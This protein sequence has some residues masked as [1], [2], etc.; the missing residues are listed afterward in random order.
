MKIGVLTYHNTRNCGAVLQAY[1]LQKVLLELGM[2][3]EIIDYRCDK[4]EETYRLRRLWEIK[5]I[6]MF[7]KW[8]LKIKSDKRTQKKFEDFRKN[9]LMLSGAYTKDNIK[10]AN[11]EFDGFITGSDQV[12][13]FHL[14]GCDY[15]Y[16]LDFA[17]MDKRKISYAASMGSSVAKDSHNK[18]FNEALASFDLVSVREKPLEEY[19]KR[20][21]GIS[22]TL[23]LDP[24][25]LLKKEGYN[26]AA[27]WTKP[28]YK[29][30]F[31]YTIATTPN[32][33]RAAREL[34][35]KTGLPI[36]WGHMSYKKK[37]GVKNLTDLAPD[38]FVSYI[39][40]AEYVLTSSFH[41]MALSIVMKKQF[42]Y[43]LDVNTQNN[44]SRLETLAEQLELNHRELSQ[45]SKNLDE[46][47]KIDY[48]A[49]DEK[50]EIKKKESMDFL[51]GI[52]K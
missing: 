40:N 9:M 19:I 5:S 44:N 11:K 42:F 32:I 47:K 22:P 48:S 28:E 8:A 29:Y 16:L 41:G 1:A 17:D 35:K 51:K 43:D 4:I 26:F 37:S 46:E 50:L 13:N 38:E 36:I 18:I 21:V 34:S 52:I 33:E 30:I 6:K 31:V 12:W 24:T 23:V 7:I 45:D 2:E 25:L 39:K 14:N 3:N 15:T 20:T 49:V 27:K 10:N